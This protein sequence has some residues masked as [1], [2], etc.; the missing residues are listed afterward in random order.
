MRGGQHAVCFLL[1]E[2]QGAYL[3]CL[4]A[5]L[6]LCGAP[7][8]GCLLP[9]RLPDLGELQLMLR[10]ASLACPLLGLQLGC[11][12]VPQMGSCVKA[13]ARRLR[14]TLCLLLLPLLEHVRCFLFGFRAR[15]L[16]GCFQYGC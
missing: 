4:L 9:Q 12:S 14:A 6:L 11:Q 2:V 10:I 13:V 8:S 5:M 1:G 7:L 15:L 16:H 3:L